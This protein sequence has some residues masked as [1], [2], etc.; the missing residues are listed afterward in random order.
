MI[1]FD[2]LIAETTV[3]F[4]SL[5]VSFASRKPHTI[6]PKNP[7]TAESNLKKNYPTELF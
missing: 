2:L 7:I 4:Q 5:L 3:W 1:S 6:S